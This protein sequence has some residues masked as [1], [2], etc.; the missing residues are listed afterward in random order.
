M[1]R[2]KTKSLLIVLGAL[3]ISAL[4]FVE[5]NVA[6][7][8]AA[9]GYT[10][11]RQALSLSDNI[12]T[13]P[14]ALSLIEQAIVVAPDNANYYWLKA[15]ILETME[16]S[17]EALPVINKALALSPTGAILWARKGAILGDLRDYKG[18][19]TCINQ[20]L[21]YNPSYMPAVRS[22]AR[23][24]M[25][26]NRFEEALANIKIGLKS[27]ASIPLE[28][29][30]WRRDALHCAMH[31]HQWQF[32]VDQASALLLATQDKN[33]RFSAYSDRARALTA[34]KKYQFALADWAAAAKL[35]P[36]SSTPHLEMAAIY[37]RMGQPARALQEQKQAETT[38]DDWAP[39]R[40]L[41]R[42]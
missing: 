19:L 1:N 10:L 21:K 27:M 26:L 5:Q 37:K 6:L 4:S 7:A 12:D 30:L 9:A 14:K 20:S 13:R 17:E 39:G 28:L 33:H 15:T 23:I 16:E 25:K 11:F 40:T 18:A 22:R 29:T 35:Q 31:L 42:Y 41:G 36:F 8:K 32:A 38:G 2:V 3:S 24:L 34:L